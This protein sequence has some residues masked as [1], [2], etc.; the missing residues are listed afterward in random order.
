M[1]FFNVLHLLCVCVGACVHATFNVTQFPCSTSVAFAIQFSFDRN[2][3]K[4]TVF[5]SEKYN[6]SHQCIPLTL[7]IFGSWIKLTRERCL[8][9]WLCYLSESILFAAIETL[10][11]YIRND[12]QTHTHTR[13]HVTP[14]TIWSTFIGCWDSKH[15]RFRLVNFLLFFLYLFV[16]VCA[17]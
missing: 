14:T 10:T 3:T 17:L 6:L 13:T 1:I 2:L 9:F 15:F 16:V 8:L 4:M 7:S 11:K 12:I 5:I